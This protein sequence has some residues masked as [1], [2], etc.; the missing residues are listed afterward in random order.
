LSQL[1]SFGHRG[2]DLSAAEASDTIAPGLL[3][4]CEALALVVMS[5]SSRV[6]SRL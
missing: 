5:A 6:A 1:A 2:S 3:L 4:S